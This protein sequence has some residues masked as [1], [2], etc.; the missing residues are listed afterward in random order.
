MG[1]VVEGRL[2]S[3]RAGTADKGAARLLRAGYAGDGQTA[4]GTPRDGTRHSGSSTLLAAI[5]T[6]SDLMAFA[7][8]QALRG[9]LRY[10]RHAPD[11]GN[12]RK[13][14]DSQKD[15]D[16]RVRLHTYCLNTASRLRWY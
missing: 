10:E 13:H 15:H 1:I 8:W 12:P 5:H 4:S 6:S 16:P 3:I 14:R 2:G 11:G 9:L 7:E